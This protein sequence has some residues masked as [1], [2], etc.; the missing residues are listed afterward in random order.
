M[1]ESLRSISARGVQTEDLE[2]MSKEIRGTSDRTAAIVHASW[3]ERTL[4]EDIIM[5]LPRHDE[6]TVDK[7]LERDGALSSFLRENP[8]RICVKPV[9]RNDARQISI[10]SDEYG[11]RLRM[12]Q[13]KSD[14]KPQKL[15]Q[16]SRNLS[17]K[18]TS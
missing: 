2:E 10:V 15:F 9:R 7:L 6:D 3:V 8:S 18:A 14:L 16:K 4:E 12:Q 17:T 1:A 5:I 13:F 11:T